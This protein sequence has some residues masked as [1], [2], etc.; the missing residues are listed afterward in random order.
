MISFN[1]NVRTVT[2]ILCLAGLSLNSAP[3]Q[4]PAQPNKLFIQILDGEG[5]LNDIRSRT[6]RADRADR[7]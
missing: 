7:R 6:A 2:A 5:A 1:Q 3:A 4:A